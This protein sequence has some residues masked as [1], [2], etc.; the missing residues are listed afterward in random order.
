MHIYIYVSIR[1]HSNK[2][3]SLVLYSTS[4]MRNP[5]PPSSPL[6]H[7]PQVIITPHVAA[8]S[9]PSDVVEVFLTNLQRYVCGVSHE[10]SSSSSTSSGGGGGGAMGKGAEGGVDA[11]IYRV[12]VTRGV[13]V[14]W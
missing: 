4:F 13:L 8:H 1:R 11:L 12:D 2:I 10:S 9:T 6:W 14:E 7:H 5:Y 3:G